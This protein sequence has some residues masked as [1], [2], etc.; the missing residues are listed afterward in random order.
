MVFHIVTM[1]DYVFCPSWL[2]TSN[3]IA[4]TTYFQKKHYTTWSHPRSKLPHQIDH[5]ISE[6]SD[7][8][9]FIDANITKPLLE[10]DHLAIKCKLRVMS[11]YRKATKYRPVS[12]LNS[13][14]LLDSGNTSNEFNQ[15]VSDAIQNNLNFSEN[16]YKNLTNVTMSNAAISTLPRKCRNSSGWLYG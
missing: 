16:A 4:V 8:C 6:K 12:R 2:E 10:S 15:F 11:N 1:Q 13:D 5:F 7:F 3:L 9:R 14:L